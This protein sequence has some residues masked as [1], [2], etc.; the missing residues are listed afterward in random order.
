[1]P[2]IRFI[3]LIFI[4]FTL[5]TSL[6]VLA[7]EVTRGPYLQMVSDNAITIRWRTDVN[8][9]S[10]V[11]FGDNVNTLNQ[12]ITVA[13]S[14]TEHELRVTGLTANTLYYY[15]VGSSLGTLAGGDSSYRF[16]TSPVTGTDKATHIWIIGDSGT[17]QAG[18]YTDADR[19]YDA[20]K[21]FPDADKTDMWI[22]LGDNAYNDGEDGEYQESVFDTYPELLRRATLWS[23]LGNH[24]GH[25]ADSDSETGPYYQIFSLPRNGESGGLASGTE[26]YYSFDYGNIHFICLDS[27]E[28]SRAANGAMM[29]WLENDLAATNQ[30]WLIA[31]WHHPPYSK[32]S[33]DSDNDSKMTDMRE[34]ALPILEDYGVDLV[35]SGHSHSYERS[36]LIDGH[37]GNSNSFTAN[38]KIDGGNG[39]GDGDG[40]YQ[41][42]IDSTHSGTVYSVAGSSGKTSGGS[43]DHPAMYHSVSQLG[44][45]VLDVNGNELTAKFLT[46]TG[47]INDYFSLSKGPDITPPVALSASVISNTQLL[48]E[49]SESL[50]SNSAQLPANYQISPEITVNT[51]SLQSNDRQVILNISELTANT[52]YQL[53]LNNINDLAGNVIAMNSQL[54]FSQTITQTVSLAQGVNGY[55]GMQD[56]Y[57]GDG[58][59]EQNFGGETSLLADGSDGSNGELVALLQWDLSTLP[60]NITLSQAE[61]TLDVFNKSGGNYQLWLAN[62]HWQQGSANWSNV[63]P[64]NNKGILVASFSP[65]T[66]G[67]YLIEINQQGLAV[68]QSWLL[69]SNNYGFYL[70]SDNSSDGIDIRSSEYATPDSRPKLTLAFENADNQLP[71]PQ[72]TYTQ[73]GLA[74]NF[75]DES[76]DS[77]GQITD[78]LWDFGDGNTSAEQHPNHQYQAAGNYPVTLTVTDNNDGT[79]STNQIIE[80][81]VTSEVSLQNGLDNYI[82]MQDCYLAS[83]NA[84]GNWGSSSEL[85]AD[86]SDG[87]NGELISLLKWQLSAIPDNATILEVSL[88]FTLFNRSG[89]SYN[90]WQM[91]QDWS[92]D[93]SSWNNSQPLTNRG[94]LLASVNPS[95]TG[96]INMTLNAAGVALVQQWLTDPSSNFGMSIASSGTVDGIDF[97]SSEH[98][99]INQ[100]PKLTIT[101][102]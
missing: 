59:P 82:G 17:D 91:N 25:S 22:M 78:W 10:V 86:G 28:T 68:M 102:F 79:S 18:Q 88:S 5:I 43:L 21:A 6:Q 41:K 3:P 32:G 72:F 58:V 8:T 97:Y 16:N 33:H 48:I 39:K 12:T 53:L 42:A 45:V 51:A 75:I 1:M 27:Y 30:Q 29:T 90:V 73:L 71:S 92:E 81:T 94:N 34:I 87:S 11:H 98:G 101:Y 60:A 44:S 19:V 62:T 61:V 69:G 99:T 84:N 47:T 74:V 63:D 57:I 64:Y 66:T 38:H 37:Y 36:Y 50:A 77:D 93:T 100:R 14:R 76:S 85:L 56:S 67:S 52:D 20:Y 26:A 35:F 49:F 24:D 65:S 40:S 7:E 15:D 4:A 55:N 83:G 95:S 70:V 9:D 46:S 80:L 31:F 13:G 89:G 96:Q 23:T 54:N 2:S